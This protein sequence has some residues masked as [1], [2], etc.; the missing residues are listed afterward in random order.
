MRCHDGGRATPELGYLRG[1][2]YW[3][4]GEQARRR[5]VI[6]WRT[7]SRWPTRPIHNFRM[8]EEKASAEK[9]TLRTC[10]P[11][12]LARVWSGTGPSSSTSNCA[13]WAE[14][15]A[16]LRPSATRFPPC[17]SSTWLLGRSRA[18]IGQQLH[19]LMWCR[20]SVLVAISGPRSGAPRE[21]SSSAACDASDRHESGNRY[22]ALLN[23][24]PMSAPVNSTGI[25]H[26]L[27]ESGPILAKFGQHPVIDPKSVG[28][29]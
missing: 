7:N 25:C 9:G 26:T 4:G 6:P 18:K 5:G 24:R 3:G 10:T 14:L 27:A 12:R 17:L 21:P 1:L 2:L 28:S 15:F 22:A 11:P 8:P 13:N 20:A 19:R 16:Q 23:E 29:G